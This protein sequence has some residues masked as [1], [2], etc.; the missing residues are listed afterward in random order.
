M[1]QGAKSLRAL[2]VPHVG[3]SSSMHRSYAAGGQLLGAYGRGNLPGQQPLESG[4]KTRHNR[5]IPRNRLRQQLLDR[6]LPGTVQWGHAFESY[7]E[8]VA[9]SGSPSTDVHLH[10]AGLPSPVVAKCLV[11]CDGIFSRVR[12]FKTAA[13]H[14]LGVGPRPEEDPLRYLGVIVILGIAAFDHPM[15]R[16]TVTQT[17]DGT[18]RW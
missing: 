18:I 15:M 2:G 14:R 13:L 3:V 6:L 4:S 12:P 10:F 16:D 11:G 8:K 5:H 7:E 17:V 9:G 1:Q